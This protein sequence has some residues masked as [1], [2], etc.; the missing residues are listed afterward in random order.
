MRS[1]I[2]GGFR[3]LTTE[4]I[5]IRAAIGEV[6]HDG[7]KEEEQ[8]TLFTSCICAGAPSLTEAVVCEEK[9]WGKERWSRVV[10]LK[11]APPLL[12]ACF[13]FAERVHYGSF[14]M[15]VCKLYS[16]GF[17]FLIDRITF[18]ISMAV[19]PY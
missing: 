9:H 17:C 18:T 11:H 3:K 8:C 2:R 19:L 5:N 1:Y 7:G 13:C 10:K 15:V 14:L 6:D 16:F 12:E 4:G